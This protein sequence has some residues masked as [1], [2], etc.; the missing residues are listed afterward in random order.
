MNDS[1]SL[2]NLND[3]VVPGAVPWWP[4]APGWYVLA[5]VTLVVLTILLARWWRQWQR[6]A[7][8]RQALN[9]LAAIRAGTQAA[10]ARALPELLKR[11]ALS[12]WPRGEVA[13]LSGPD[14]HRFLD[15]SAGIERFCGNAGVTLDQLAYAGPAGELPTADSLQQ[16]MDATETW[17]RRHQRQAA[18]N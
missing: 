12:A 18:E 4:L 17:L 9:E 5:G 2:Q 1:G 11:T 15:Q 16:V 14:W 7:Y 13:A 8:R 10:S 3:I 6:D